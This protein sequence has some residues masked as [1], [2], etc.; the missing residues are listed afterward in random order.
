MI[1]LM[2]K[3]HRRKYHFQQFQTES[4]EFVTFKC[5]SDIRQYRVTC[6]KYANEKYG[7]RSVCVCVFW[8]VHYDTLIIEDQFSSTIRNTGHAYLLQSQLP[9][10]M[11][12]IKHAIYLSLSFLNSRIVYPISIKFGAGRFCGYV[13]ANL[14]GQSG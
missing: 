9:M 2:N 10:Q 8:A 7:V 14:S 6:E 5:I 13:W 12:N 1:K 4:L 3:N 11:G